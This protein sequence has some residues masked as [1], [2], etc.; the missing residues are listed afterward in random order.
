MT[1]SQIDLLW[2]F[3]SVG[4]AFV[5]WG[6]WSL[7]TIAVLFRRVAHQLGATRER[8]KSGETIWYDLHCLRL[9]VGNL[10]TALQRQKLVTVPPKDWSD[11]ALKTRQAGIGG[12]EMTP[13][14]WQPA[15]TPQSAE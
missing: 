4:L 2:T 5:A 15:K 14:H 12:L 1:P 11:D 9:Q 6:S 7:W 13:F 10:I 8:L 3:L